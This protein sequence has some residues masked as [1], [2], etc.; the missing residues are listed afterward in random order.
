[1][2]ETL[3]GGQDEDKGGMR[4][5]NFATSSV[6][7]PP[8]RRCLS[9]P[10]AHVMENSVASSLMPIRT[11]NDKVDGRSPARR[12]HDPSPTRNILHQARQPSRTLRRHPVLATMAPTSHA[13]P[14]PR[15][16]AQDTPLALLTSALSLLTLLLAIL[17][18]VLTLTSL[19]RAA[20]L[21]R[22]AA[23]AEALRL[24]ARLD[25]VARCAG[26]EVCVRGERGAESLL[27]VGGARDALGRL[28]RDL[29][30]CGGVEGTARGCR[31]W[32]EARWRVGWMVLGGRRRVEVAEARVRGLVGEVEGLQGGMLER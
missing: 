17:S 4:H 6:L 10:L 26:E 28:K 3:L 19:L 18:T 23:R 13:Q 24:A 20:P 25:A 14:Q 30:C 7:L 9:L 11:L 31:W 22:A 21:E 8:S 29:E 2:F 27:A 1:M 5:Y 15:P 32:E 16:G 12:A